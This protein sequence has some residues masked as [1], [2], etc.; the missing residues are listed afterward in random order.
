MPEAAL[1]FLAWIIFV[2]L[3]VIVVAFIFRLWVDRNM[4]KRPGYV[5]DLTY[6]RHQRG[7]DPHAWEQ[8]CQESLNRSRARRARGRRE[9]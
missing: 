7:S 8:A 6:F 2:G 5:E 4:P 9:G 1:I 3:I